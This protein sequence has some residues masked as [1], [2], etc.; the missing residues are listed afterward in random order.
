MWKGQSKLIALVV[1]SAMSLL[2]ACGGEDATQVPA[3]P[4]APTKVPVATQASPTATRAAQ[5]SGICAQGN[6]PAYIKEMVL[7]K[8]VQGENFTPVDITDA[9][10]PTQATFHAIVTLQDAPQNLKL[11]SKWYLVQAAGYTPNTKIDENE[12]PVD[13][14]GSRNVDFTLKTT[15]DAWPSGTYCVEIYAAGNLVLSKNFTVVANT[16]P[17]NAMGS[18][19]KQIV[20]AQDAR[21]ATFEPV[22]PTTTFKANAPTIH[23]TVEI[24]DAP[25]NTNLRARWYPPTQD[26]LDFDLTADGTRWID[27]RLTPAPDGFPTGEYKA[28]IYVN[29]E[30]VDTQTFTVE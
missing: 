8:D 27:F 4:L 15:Q 20:L 23:A 5:A 16:A 18:V 2:A 14:G 12:L 22:N 24:Q 10:A 30:L 3:T 7:A 29:Q 26:P 1:L 21:P 6:L 25:A 28:E 17:S 9:Y 11:A 19:V 13:Q